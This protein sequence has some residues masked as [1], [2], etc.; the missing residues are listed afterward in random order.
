MILLK[1]SNKKRDTKMDFSMMEG[2]NRVCLRASASNL[3]YGCTFLLLFDFFKGNI[4]RNF[5]RK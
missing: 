1:Q 4:Q 3:K 2:R 5:T